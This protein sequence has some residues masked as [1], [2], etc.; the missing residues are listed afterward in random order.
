MPSNNRSRKQPHSDRDY[1]YH[2]FWSNI[3]L[4]V[5]LYRSSEKKVELERIPYSISRARGQTAAPENHL[6]YGN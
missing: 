1:S 2:F 6:P 5:V 3:L 4:A